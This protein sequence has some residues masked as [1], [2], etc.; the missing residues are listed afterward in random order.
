MSLCGVDIG[1]T[2]CK[3]VVYSLDGKLLAAAYREYAVLH[4]QPDH[5]EL[6]AAKVWTLVCD[7]IAEVSH[8]A[9]N[10]AIQAISVSSLGEAMVPVTAGREILGNSILCMDSRGDEYVARLLSKVSADD[11]FGINRNSPDRAY[12][13]PKLCWIKEHQPEIYANADLFLSWAD[14]ACFMLGGEA[15]ACSSL[16]ARTLLYDVQGGCWSQKLLECSG[17]GDI[18]GK[19]ADVVTAGTVLGTVSSGIMNKLGL[20]GEVEIVAGGHDQCCNALGAGVRK[21]G[22]AVYG[23]GTFEC[24]TP[25]FDSLSAAGKMKSAGLC[26]EAHVLPDRYVTFLYNQGGSLVKWFRDTFASAEIASGGDIYNR[27]CDEMPAEPT[28]L[29]TLPFFEPSGPPKYI[30]DAAGVIIGLRNSTSRGEILRSIMESITYYMA[31]GAMALKD[32]GG[33]PEKFVVTGGGAKSDVWLQI[34]ADIFG[35][36]FVRKNTVECSALGAAMLAGMGAKLDITDE[37]NFIETEKVFE[38]NVDL[39][40]IYSERL[41]EYRRWVEVILAEYHAKR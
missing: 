10:D 26:T 36:P 28:R 24:I 37:E 20:H 35:L 31:D 22:E 14:F 21:A 19:L 15:K 7:I 8:H 12:S 32:C 39:H 6:D 41:C 16:A 17:L 30:T 33:Y 27:L 40:T 5:A 3:A 18:R 25:V 11:I 38:P 29:F 23:I 13:M 2:G 4:P 34:K 1:T 9:E